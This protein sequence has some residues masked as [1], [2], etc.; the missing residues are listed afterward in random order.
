MIEKPKSERKKGNNQAV[1]SVHTDTN[2]TIALASLVE[3]EMD[4]YSLNTIE[5]VS[6]D[7]GGHG[8]GRR[9]GIVFGGGGAFGRA[10]CAH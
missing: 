3:Q 4:W 2:G 6:L 10:E 8:V 9:G 5:M 7:P 1:I